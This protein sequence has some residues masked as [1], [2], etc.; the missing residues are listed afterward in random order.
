M[1][2]LLIERLDRYRDGGTI[3]V[4]CFG[5]LGQNEK[6]QELQICLDKRAGADPTGKLWIGY[7][8][9]ADSVEIT[10]EETISHI[11]EELRE[12][13]ERQQ[14]YIDEVIDACSKNQ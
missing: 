10:D 1:K 5:Y 14:F 11:I 8:G 6:S 2:I 3:S 13:K 12:Y 4:K 7:P 9:K